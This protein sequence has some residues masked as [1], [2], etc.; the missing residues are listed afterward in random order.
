[1][2]TNVTIT[3]TLEEY[4]AHKERQAAFDKEHA[5]LEAL[6]H[7]GK[8]LAE[9]VCRELKALLDGEKAKLGRRTAELLYTKAEAIL[10]SLKQ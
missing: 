5:E 3:M 9:M 2:E 7:D 6:Q 10:R 1:M 4:A 8:I